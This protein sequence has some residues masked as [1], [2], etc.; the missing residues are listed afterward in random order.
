[1]PVVRVCAAHGTRFPQGE[2]CPDP[3]HYDPKAWANTAPRKALRRLVFER[4]YGICAAEVDGTTHALSED[5]ELHHVIERVKGGSDDPSNIVGL[6]H[7]CH[8][9]IGRAR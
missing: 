8:L 5:W 3:R 6:C 7:D 2:R 4:Q 1:M 9:K